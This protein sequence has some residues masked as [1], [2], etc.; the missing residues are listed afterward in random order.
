M[1]ASLLLG[2]DSVVIG[3]NG[4]WLDGTVKIATP[5]PVTVSAL[6]KKDSKGDVQV[7]AH[8][9]TG[10]YIVRDVALRRDDVVLF[11]RIREAAQRLP[12]VLK[13]VVI[14]P[15][16]H[17]VRRNGAYVDEVRETVYEIDF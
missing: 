4:E 7:F 5:Y 1:A 10:G 9:F 3:E 6:K 8:R 17:N 14:A 11:A 13:S 2:S 12:L 16:T 15:M